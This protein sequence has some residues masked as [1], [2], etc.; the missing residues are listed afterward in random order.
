MSGGGGGGGG[1]NLIARLAIEK[2][3]NDTLTLITNT[4][5]I[6]KKREK[7]DACEGVTFY[8]SLPALPCLSLLSLNYKKT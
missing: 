3:R 4:K 8:L 6:K 7:D 5:S 1:I 2:E